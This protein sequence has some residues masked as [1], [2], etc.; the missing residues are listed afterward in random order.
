MNE[1]HFK[2]PITGNDCRADCMW[3]MYVKAS[4]FY[5]C[6]VADGLSAMSV[7]QVVQL[8]GYRKDVDDG[9]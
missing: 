4:G 2:C 6:S 1:Q 5:V 7:H 9:R 8:N 3:A